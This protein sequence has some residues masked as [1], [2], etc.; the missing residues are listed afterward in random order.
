VA[1]PT[2]SLLVNLRPHIVLGFNFSHALDTAFPHWSRY[3]GVMLS[4]GPIPLWLSAV[5]LPLRHL[6]FDGVRT[7]PLVCTLCSLYDLSATIK[8]CHPTSLPLWTLKARIVNRFV[9]S[10]HG[11][12]STNDCSPRL[13]RQFLVGGSLAR[14]VGSRW[15]LSRNAHSPKGC[16]CCTCF[17]LAVYTL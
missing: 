5:S 12:P 4:T 2:R 10:A 8:F 13:A 7:F 11:H 15:P 1:R 16:L 3:F 9:F 17:Q 14:F 6:S